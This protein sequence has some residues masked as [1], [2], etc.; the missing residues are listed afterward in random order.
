MGRCRVSQVQ[1]REGFSVAQWHIHGTNLARLF[2]SRPV[3][4]FSFCKTRP[5]HRG[6]CTFP[7]PA[8]EPLASVDTAVQYSEAFSRGE[9]VA[10]A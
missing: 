4:A 1:L 9:H 6:M 7:Y 8:A 3:E 10:S 5:F 2:K